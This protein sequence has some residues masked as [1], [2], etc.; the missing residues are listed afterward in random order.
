MNS[1]K[2]QNIGSRIS[3][4]WHESSLTVIIAQHIPRT[5]RL[6]LE[7]WFLAWLFVGVASSVEFAE[8]VGSDRSFYLIFMAFWGFF[9][10][11]VLKSSCGARWDVR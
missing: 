1:S 6:M 4:A 5:Q 8:A 10:F 7:A 11:R 2:V 3:Y 9:A